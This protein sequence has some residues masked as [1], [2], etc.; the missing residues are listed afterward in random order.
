M[1]SNK[2]NNVGIKKDKKWDALKN[3]PYSVKDYIHTNHGPWPQPAPDNPVRQMAEVVHL[4]EEELAD[5]NKNV[6]WMYKRRVLTCWPF[7]IW[8][9]LTHSGYNEYNDEQFRKEI[10][11]GL[12]SKFMTDL[13]TGD[14]ALFK[15]YLSDLS[16]DHQYVKA[17]FSCME[18]IAPNCYEGMWA[19]PTIT[20]ISKKK[21]NKS[22]FD[23]EPIAIYLY[24]V[25]ENKTSNSAKNS[26]TRYSV[27]E[28]SIF[29]PNDGENW[30]LAKY[31]VLQGAVHRVNLTEHAILH[32]PFDCINAITKSI[33]PKHH[34]LFQLLFP[35]FRLSLGV[36]RAVLENSGSLINR[37]KHRFYSPFCAEGIHIRQLLPDG[38][39]GREGKDKAYPEYEFPMEPKI[40]DSDFGKYLQ[41]YYNVFAKFVS[42]VLNQ[43]DDDDEES[44]IYIALW[45]D[46]ICEWMPGFPDREG[47]TSDRDGGIVKPTKEGREKLNKVV[48]MILWD[49]SLAHATDHIA[50]HEKRPHGNPFRLRVP[51]PSKDSQPDKNWRKQLVSRLDLLT[52]WFTDL[53]FYLPSN[54]TVLEEVDYSFSLRDDIRDKATKERYLNQEAENFRNALQDCQ[55]RLKDDGV[56]L[57]AQLNQISASLQY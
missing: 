14:L 26:K 27:K 52:F 25:A 36:N 53:L 43:L 11:E 57:P 7:G 35:H 6:G 44:W 24:Q 38:Y 20:L 1:D 16:D 3:Y 8:Y 23:Y 41:A 48:T 15:S 49:L 5:W 34:L 32:F 13:D 21:N 40:P 45:A 12:Y 37:D 55:Q 56:E 51:P 29:T 42:K 2:R 31:F 54:V 39:I 22:G 19:A 30:H 28:Y 18:P 50:I 4:P 33:L 47:L 9:A 46:C 10:T 17:D